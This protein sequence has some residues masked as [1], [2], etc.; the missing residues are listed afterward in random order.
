VV[1][2]FNTPHG[3][4]GS[5]IVAGSWGIALAVQACSRLRGA[6]YKNSWWVGVQVAGKR[7]EW[8]KAPRWRGFFTGLVGLAVSLTLLVG[9][10]WR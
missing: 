1:K 4:V 5:L 9:C 2:T 6:L 3:V 7:R 8:K 10:R